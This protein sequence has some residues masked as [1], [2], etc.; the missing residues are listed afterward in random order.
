MEGDLVTKHIY[1]HTYFIGSVCE[2][3]D[4][5]SNMEGKKG[6]AY[7]FVYMFACFKIGFYV[8]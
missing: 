8:S 1:T 5:I 4:S 3:Q 7:L 2:A 6:H